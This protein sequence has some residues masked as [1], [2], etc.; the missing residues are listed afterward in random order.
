MNKFTFLKGFMTHSYVKKVNNIET[1]S[2][3]MLKNNDYCNNKLVQL[4]LKLNGE[5]H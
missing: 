2:A 5:I 4:Y 1:D 3:Y